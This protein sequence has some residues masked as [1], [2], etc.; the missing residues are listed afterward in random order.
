MKL[1]Q[2]AVIYNNL[3]S[4]FFTISYIQKNAD[5]IYNV[6]I[7]PLYDYGILGLPRTLLGLRTDTT[8]TD[9]VI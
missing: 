2:V 6:A 1:K 3:N 9:L 8:E 5:I 4:K 7:S